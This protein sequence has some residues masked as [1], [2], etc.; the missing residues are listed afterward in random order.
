MMSRLLQRPSWA[1]LDPGEWRN[2]RRGWTGDKQAGGSVSFF[3]SSSWLRSTW[4]SSFYCI[5]V[6]VA[7]VPTGQL[8]G[9]KNISTVLRQQAL[10]KS[11]PRSVTVHIKVLV[12]ELISHFIQNKTYLQEVQC[13]K[14]D[15]VF[16]RSCHCPGIFKHLFLGIFPPT[17]NS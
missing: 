17:A 7:Q 16:E 9:F 13:L 3:S 10:S 8:L 2:W 14:Q 11:F 1:Q 5:P 15:L 6:S 4:S 12:L